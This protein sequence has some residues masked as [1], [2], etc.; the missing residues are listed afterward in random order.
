MGRSLQQKPVVISSLIV[1]ELELNHHNIAFKG[2]K[3]ENVRVPIVQD[4]ENNIQ[5][6]SDSNLE[7]VTGWS[8]LLDLLVTFQN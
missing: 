5:P 1:G 7:S 3:D 4:S 6:A 8:T 2:K